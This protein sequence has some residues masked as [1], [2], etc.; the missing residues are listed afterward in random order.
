MTVPDAA[1]RGRHGLDIESGEWLNRGGR[2]TRTWSRVC[3]AVQDCCALTTAASRKAP[4]PFVRK[5]NCTQCHFSTAQA[6]RTVIF[7]A[8]SIRWP[9]R[10]SRTASR[11]IAA[12]TVL[13]MGPC[14]TLK[15]FD[16]ATGGQGP[17]FFKAPEG[18][19]Y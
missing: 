19:P 3:H 9:L 6:M 5:A 16:M 10:C 8:P 11:A 4:L 13:R 1:R 2:H 18:V 14:L 12:R 15:H 17:S 7:Y